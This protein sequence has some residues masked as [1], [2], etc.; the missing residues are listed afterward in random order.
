[1]IKAIVFD[2]FGV[3][4]GHSAAGWHRQEALLTFVQELKAHY[5]IGMLTNLGVASVESLFPAPERE[6]LFDATVIAGEI[7]IAKPRPEIY[8]AICEK[9]GVE[10][11]EAIFVDDINANNAAA[12]AIGMHTILYRDLSAFQRDLSAILHSTDDDTLK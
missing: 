5:K 10:P 2:C 11:Q 12:E 6:K 7:G 1:M 3:L 9:L 4:G 8:H